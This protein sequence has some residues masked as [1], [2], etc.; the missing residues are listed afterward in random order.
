MSD[1]QCDRCEN[2]RVPEDDDGTRW[3]TVENLRFCRTC[4]HEIV[5]EY[6]KGL[7]RKRIGG[8]RT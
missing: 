5:I 7:A 4:V 2:T 8:G 3:F 1:D 6:V